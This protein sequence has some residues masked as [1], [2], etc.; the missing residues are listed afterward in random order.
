M[1]VQT[2]FKRREIKFLLSAEQKAAVLEAIAPYMK[3]DIYGKSVICNIYL[4]TDNFRLI[5]RSIEK[6]VYKEKIRLRSYGT[7]SADEN[8]FV[9]LKKKLSGVVYKRRL[10]LP[11]RD[12]MCAIK[13]GKEFE[14]DSQIGRELNY[15]RHFYEN[16]T[17]RVFLS[18]EREAFFAKESGLRLTL[19][20]NILY[21]T[22]NLTL[23]APPYGKHVLDEGLTLMEIKTPSAIPLWLSGE[24]SRH[25]I[26]KQSFSK[27]GTAYT[28]LLKENYN[29]KLF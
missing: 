17:P 13:E 2:V 28:D 7:V 24:L 8:I 20:E 26:F 25:K 10:S 29:G 15:F 12:V 5:R 19:D 9:E 23:T 14:N 3:P 21:R 11:Q 1:N 16:P 6:P 4:D 22:D 27:Y 18:Y